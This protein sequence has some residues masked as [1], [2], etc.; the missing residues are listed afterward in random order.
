M[1]RSASSIMR[2]VRPLLGR[3]SLD[4]ER[5]FQ[6]GTHSSGWRVAAAASSLWLVKSIRNGVI[7]T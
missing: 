7:E 6:R 4:F 2:I 5:V 1:T 3:L